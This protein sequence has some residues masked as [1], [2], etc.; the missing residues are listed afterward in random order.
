MA[1]QPAKKSGCG[2]YILGLFAAFILIIFLLAMCDGTADTPTPTDAP[3]QAEASVPTTL[4]QTEPPTAPQLPPMSPEEFLETVQEH[5]YWFNECAIERFGAV[6]SE[7]TAYARVYSGPD[8]MINGEDPI[9]IVRWGRDDTLTDPIGA[10][11][12]VVENYTAIDQVRQ[13]LEGYIEPD[14]AALLLTEVFQ[15]FEGTLYYATGSTGT[16]AVYYDVNNASVMEVGTEYAT[17]FMDRFFFDQPD[18]QV[19]ITFRKTDG[20]WYISEYQDW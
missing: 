2:S 16:G 15:E 19:M 6:I 13:T 7:D 18:G 20:N 17:V 11:L 5:L 4:P 9:D 8:A 3:T 1:E 12:Y 10:R 14:L